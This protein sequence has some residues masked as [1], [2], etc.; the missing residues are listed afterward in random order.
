MWSFRWR[1]TPCSSAWW[2]AWWPTFPCCS[3]AAWKYSSEMERGTLARRWI[4]LTEKFVH[5]FGCSKNHTKPMWITMIYRINYFSKV[6][7]GFPGFLLQRFRWQMSLHVALGSAIR[8]P[9]LA[10]DSDLSRRTRWRS[11]GIGCLSSDLGRDPQVPLRLFSENVE[12]TWCRHFPRWVESSGCVCPQPEADA[13]NAQFEVE[14][15]KLRH[16]AITEMLLERRS[17]V[18]LGLLK[19]P[20]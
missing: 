8:P 2:P 11:L 18:V 13:T 5:H 10:K 19:W 3:M 20:I 15:E 14:S 17:V 6:P 9:E 12:P 4:Q 7:T 16:N 1:I